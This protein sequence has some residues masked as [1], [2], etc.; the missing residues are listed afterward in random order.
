[1]VTKGLKWVLTA[2][3]ILRNLEGLSEEWR[4]H[5]LVHGGT[6]PVPSGLV[7]LAVP[8]VCQA[9][10]K[11]VASEWRR[12][13]A[14]TCIGGAVRSCRGASRGQAFS[15]QLLVPEHNG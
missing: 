10:G 7:Q 3:T 6:V 5:R 15:S 13:C 2:H 9:S 11:R 1:M 12:G 8:H 4:T 14:G